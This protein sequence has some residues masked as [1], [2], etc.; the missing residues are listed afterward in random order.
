M[1]LRWLNTVIQS[2]RLR[3][4]LH[5]LSPICTEMKL[6]S[7]NLLCNPFVCIIEVGS[8]IERTKLDSNEWDSLSYFSIQSLKNSSNK[9]IW[10]YSNIRNFSCL[11]TLLDIWEKRCFNTYWR[12]IINE[13]VTLKT[14][15][16]AQSFITKICNSPLALIWQSTIKP[17]WFC[18]FVFFFLFC[19]NQVLLVLSNPENEP[20]AVG[21]NAA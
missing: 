19:R 14:N 13:K 15:K 17:F 9:L 11:C 3:R 10:H 12:C 8:W 1:T 6:I 21:F 16:Q 20:H 2:G 4:L 18:F 5:C 7:L